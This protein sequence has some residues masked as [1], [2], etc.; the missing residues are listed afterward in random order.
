MNTYIKILPIAILLSA[1]MDTTSSGSGTKSVSAT[2]A[3]TQSRMAQNGA[4]KEV[5]S[6]P[7]M[8]IIRENFAGNP[9]QFSISTEI[10]REGKTSQRFE[11]RHGDCGKSNDCKNDRMRVEM[12]EDDERHEAPVGSK[13]WYSWSMYLNNDFDDIDG[14]NTLVGQKK[15][16]GWRSPLWD[17]NI[18]RD[19]LVV[20]YSPLG[21]YNPTDCRT[22][23]L[24]EMRGRW[25][26]MMVFADYGTEVSNTPKFQAW[27][28]GKLWCET[29]QNLITDKMVK[30]S[31]K[32]RVMFRYGIYTSYVSK[33]LDKNKTKAVN[34]TA[35]NDVDEDGGGST[36]SVTARPFDIDWGVE[37]PTMVIHY[38]AVKIGKTR[39]EVKI[40]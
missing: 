32:D 25:T 29:T 18:E 12:I 40:N 10:A 7:H 37:L 26:D 39:D 24:S 9:H 11:L 38:D 22:L 30:V 28:N 13:L 35:F 19:H 23:N 1:C 3:S 4:K 16:L 31:N 14:L 2:S 33:W 15:L 20:K 8:R 5:N 6:P 36:M 27:I 21:S 34:V 17:F